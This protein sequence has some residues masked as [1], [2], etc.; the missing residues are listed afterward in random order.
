VEN[1]WR[2]RR[3][4]EKEKMST[5]TMIQT[6]KKRRGRPCESRT[7]PNEPQRQKQNHKENFFNEE[8]QGSS[9]TSLSAPVPVKS[10]SRRRQARNQ[11]Q[12]HT[13]ENDTKKRELQRR[14]YE[15]SEYFLQ[16]QAKKDVHGL[17]W[18]IQNINAKLRQKQSEHHELHDRLDWSVERDRVGREQHLKICSV[19]EHP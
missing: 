8:S 14:V 15:A 9:S 16:L 2:I 1:K 11:Q 18:Q 13:D 19:F 17:H 4:R 7:D 12:L 6:K 5:S 3:E 10:R